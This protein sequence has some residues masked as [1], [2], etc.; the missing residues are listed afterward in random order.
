MVNPDGSRVVVFPNGT[1]KTTAADGKS[2]VIAFFNGDVKQVKPD[3]SVVYY[4]AETK[5]TQTT[6]ADGLEV[7]HFAK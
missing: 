6:Q 1:R 2:V 4:Y 3:Q 5:T 7:L